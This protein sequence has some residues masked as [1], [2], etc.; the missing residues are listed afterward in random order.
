MP[1]RDVVIHLG[2]REIQDIEQAVLDADEAAALDFLRR[3]L[4][5]RIDEMLKRPHCKPVFEWGGETPR[6][7]GPPDRP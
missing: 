4:K 3:V 5:P 1:A 6:P 2:E 7:A